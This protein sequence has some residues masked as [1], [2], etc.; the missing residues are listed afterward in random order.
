MLARHPSGGIR[1]YFRYVYGH[2]SMNDVSLTFMNPASDAMDP[3][4]SSLTN[5][6]EVIRTESTARSLFLALIRYLKRNKPDLIQSH[7]FTAAILASI[8]AKILKINHI[9]TTHDIFLADQFSGFTGTLKHWVIGKVLGLCSVVNPVGEDARENLEKNYP[10]L[11]HRNKVTAIRNGIE[12]Q[13]FMTEEC[14]NLREEAC[15]PESALLVGFFGRFMAQ[16]GFG[17][18]VDAVESW[19]RNS[20]ARPLHVACFGWGGFIREDQ[21]EIQARGLA[22]CF[23]FFSQ[24]DEMAQ[25]LRGVDAVVMPSRW[26][27]CPLLPMEAMT[28]GTPVIGSRC[29]GLR[30]VVA[31]TPA[32][33]FDVNS[34][35]DLLKTLQ[36]FQLEYADIRTEA[37]AFRPEAAK[38]FD[39]GK[40]A[41]ALR[42][43]YQQIL[44]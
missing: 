33:M 27:A 4:V 24:T 22:A 2:A 19:N 5:V 15:I 20:S 1:T 10:L 9:A 13:A 43:L 31:D 17:T 30:E 38:R 39:V 14:R 32:L 8:P 28:A 42:Q 40:T 23:H 16:K 35:T 44:H 29:I 26:E 41:I 25:A 12:T 6:Q 21:A 7:G 18:L 11:A 3:I 37:K 34:K 36:R